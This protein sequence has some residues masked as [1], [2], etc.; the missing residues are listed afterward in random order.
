MLTAPTMD[1]YT[2]FSPRKYTNRQTSARFLKPKVDG[3][4]ISARGQKALP[5][6]RP[7]RLRKETPRSWC[8]SCRPSWRWPPFRCPEPR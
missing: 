5:Q 1:P 4:R 6:R 2:E 8:V 7:R 3:L